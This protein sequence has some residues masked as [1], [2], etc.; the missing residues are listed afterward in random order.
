MNKRLKLLFSINHVSISTYLTFLIIL[1]FLIGPSFLEIVELKTMDLRFKSRGTMKASDAVVLAVID[2]KSLDKE[3]R[4]PWARSKIAR[5]IDYLSDDG[6]K[7]IGFDIGFL[8][9]DEN[10]N[11]FFIQQLESK[12]AGLKLKNKE[13]DR[14]LSESKS[15]ADNDLIL[16]NAIKRSKAKVVS[17]YFFHMSQKGLDYTIEKE[18]IKKYIAQISGSS[19]PHYSIL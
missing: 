7:V 8:E 2:E 3:G 11:L 12:I 17:G 6:A 16:A 13:L 10:N 9:P 5:L 15:L 4:W 18:T 1:I 19:Y 14:F